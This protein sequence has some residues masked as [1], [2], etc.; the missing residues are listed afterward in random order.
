MSKSTNKSLQDE[1]MRPAPTKGDGSRN[2][3]ASHHLSV[4]RGG[5]NTARK[6]AGS[7]A[8]TQDSTV[9]TGRGGY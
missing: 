1:I 5:G 6:R 2:P 4:P 7:G 9:K 3:G 8:G